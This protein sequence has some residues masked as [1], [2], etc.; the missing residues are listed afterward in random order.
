MSERAHRGKVKVSNVDLGL[1]I[2]LA[3]P[4]ALQDLGEM[5]PEANGDIR[6]EAIDLVRFLSSIRGDDQLTELSGGAFERVETLLTDHKYPL[7]I[8]D[9]H[10]DDESL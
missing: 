10:L 3:H 8:A 7:D 1:L 9:W 5:R 4:E 6:I 2:Q